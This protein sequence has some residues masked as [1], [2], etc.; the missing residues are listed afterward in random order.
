MRGITDCTVNTFKT[1]LDRFLGLVSDEPSVPD[2]TARCRTS[3]SIPTQLELINRDARVGS[4]AQS[5]PPL[6]GIHL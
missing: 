4:S 5:P 6:P 3:N 2:Y 1:G